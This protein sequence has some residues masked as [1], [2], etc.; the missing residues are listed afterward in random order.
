MRLTGA[1]MR[2][3]KHRIAGN[4]PPDYQELIAILRSEHGFAFLQ[5]IMGGHCPAWWSGVSRAKNLG[6]MRRQIAQQ[7]RRLAQLEMEIE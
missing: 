5:F 6:D 2:T 4:R 3:A 1:K 7:Q